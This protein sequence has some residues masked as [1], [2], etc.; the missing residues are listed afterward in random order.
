MGRLEYELKQQ[1]W[2]AKDALAKAARLRTERDTLRE[3]NA[4]RKEELQACKEE[5]AAAR[6]SHLGDIRSA[7]DTCDSQGKKLMRAEETATC[8]QEE[9]R[10]AREKLEDL[11]ED[12]AMEKRLNA[13]MAKEVEGLKLDSAAA[14]KARR[15]YEDARN[16]ADRY[17][18][19]SEALTTLLSEGRRPD[20]VEFA[21]GGEGCSALASE[22]ASYERWREPEAHSSKARSRATKKLRQEWL[23]CPGGL[24]FVGDGDLNERI[25]AVTVRTGGGFSQVVDVQKGCSCQSAI[26]PLACIMLLLAGLP[27]SSFSPTA[28]PYRYLRLSFSS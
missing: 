2:A 6:I 21:T 27:V 20:D 3:E 10:R 28:L 23:S 24:A 17:R 16:E 25:R 14:I 1:A 19:E 8:L 13:G 5:L 15:M 22:E 4:K 12:L 18:R 11:R 26:P 9:L 7:K